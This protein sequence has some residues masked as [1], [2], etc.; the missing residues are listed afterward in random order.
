M[1]LTAEDD[2]KIITIE[3]K[4]PSGHISEIVTLAR[5]VA[6]AMEFHPDTVASNLPTE[7]EL[8]RLLE[9]MSEEI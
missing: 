5:G 2:H 9:D 6:F 7:E 4:N 1:K 8:D 3:I